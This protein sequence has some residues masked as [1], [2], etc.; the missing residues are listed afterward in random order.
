MQTHTH[1]SHTQ[2]T[3]SYFFS[4]P[5]RCCETIEIA[6]RCP[7]GTCFRSSGERRF[8]S[9][10]FSICLACLCSSC[11]MPMTWSA[12]E[13]HSRARST[14]S[15]SRWRLRCRIS[16]QQCR[17]DITTAHPWCPVRT[18]LHG[19]GHSLHQDCILPFFFSP[20]RISIRRQSGRHAQDRYNLVPKVGCQSSLFFSKALILRLCPASN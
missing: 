9:P 17:R 1:I 13:A 11:L 18:C 10:L 8:S 5:T 2:P 16:L 6:L 19:G 14:T 12:N 15:P 7:R 20:C 3:A 4:F